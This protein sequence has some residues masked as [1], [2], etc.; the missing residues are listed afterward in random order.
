MNEQ[1]TIKVREDGPLLVSG[2]AKLIDFQGN[3][4]EVGDRGDFVL[5]R[6]GH[7]EK[8]PFCDGAHKRD[9]FQAGETAVTEQ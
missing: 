2:P 6:C 8:R 5:C 9:G 1:V 7:S 3:E 4:F